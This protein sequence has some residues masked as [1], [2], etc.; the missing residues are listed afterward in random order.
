MSQQ[1]PQERRNLKS[2]IKMLRAFARHEMSCPFFPD[3]VRTPRYPWAQEAFVCT[4][5][6][7]RIDSRIDE[8]VDENDEDES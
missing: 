3:Q 2:V 5:G 4:C 1:D 7:A 8:L 6:L